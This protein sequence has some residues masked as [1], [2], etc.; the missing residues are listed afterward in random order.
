MISKKMKYA[1]KALI[2]I[3]EHYAEQV[4][5]KDIAEQARIPKKFLEQILLDLK[6]S[7][8]INSKQGNAGGYYFLKKPSEVALSDIY[9][10]ID[11]PI[12]LLGCVSKNFY[13]PCADCPDEAGCK[14][15]LALYQVREQT[16]TVMENITIADLTK[17]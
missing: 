12:A 17:D 13:E 2:Y 16:L 6:R 5:T 15:R 1:L 9:R 11:G 3:A 8:I 10:I 7:C 4:K 14:I